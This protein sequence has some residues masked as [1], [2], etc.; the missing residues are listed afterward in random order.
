M[1]FA[2]LVLAAAL[3]PASLVNTFVGTS[4]TQIG[5]P[6]DDFPGADAPFGM[7]QWSP[8]T[9]SQ[10]AG[11][12]YEYGDTAIT[13]FSLTHL[14]GPG[15]SVFG[16]FAML[17]TTGDITSPATAKQ[18]FSHATE[19][20]APGDYA[21]TLGNPGIRAELVARAH[22][23]IGRFT[24]PATTRANVLVNVASN[25][26]GVTDA[27]A[28]IVGNDEIEG[29]AASGYFCGMPDRYSVYFVARFNRPFVASGVWGGG[30]GAGS[31]AWVRFDTTRNPNVEVNVAISFTDAA[32]ARANLDREGR[33][34]DLVAARNTVLASWNAM[35]SRIA[36]E[37][38]TS[39]QQRQ[40]Y[41]ALYHTMLHPNLISDVDGR[42]RGFD[43]AIHHARVGREYANFSDWDIY[44][45]EIPLIALLA[46]ARASD[47]MQSLV[48]AYAQSGW[49]PRW[50]LVNAP[51]SVMGGDS[52]DPV[53]AGGYAF[54]ARDFDTKT[55]L[56]GMVKGSSD[57][58]SPPWDGWYFERPESREYQRQGYISNTHTTSVSPVPNGASETLEYALDDFSIA[59]FARD[60]GNLGVYRTYL[61]RSTN[62]SN[63]FN[64]ATGLIAPRDGT[65]AFTSSPLNENGQDGFQE[66]NAAQYTWMVP[67][68]L[69]DLARGMG[70]A[71]NTAAALD[72]FFTQLNAGQDKPY[73]WLGNEPSIG[74]PWVYLSVGEPWRTQ[75][76]VRDAMTT[77][78]TL[79]PDGIPGN[80]DLGTMSAWYVWSAIG[81]YPQNPSV[82]ILDI[83][84]PLFPHI[85]LQS[86]H[87]PTLVIHAPAAAANAPYVDALRVNGR[88]TQRAWFALPMTGM[89]HLH[90]DLS[91]QPNHAWGAKPNDAPPSFA[92]RGGVH[93]PPATASTLSLE[94]IPPLAPGA[95]AILGGTLTN[96]DSIAQSYIVSASVSQ[97]ATIA[98]NRPVE[99]LTLPPGKG[100]VV[101]FQLAIPRGAPVG[102][103]DA[104]IHVRTTS[105]ALLPPAHV[106][107]R[108]ANNAEMPRLA[109]IENRFNDTVMPFDLRTNAIGATV[110]V[111]SGPRDAVLSLDNRRLFVA[112]RDSQSV[113]VVD[114]IASKVIATLKVGSSPNGIAL[115]PDGTVWVANFDD[116]TVQSI[117][118]VTFATGKPI[119]V[120]AGP[121]YITVGPDNAHLYV[122]DQ[123]SNDLTVVDLK[124][125]STAT[126]PTGARPTGITLSA[127]GAIAYVANNGDRTVSVIDLRAARIVATIPAGAEAQAVAISP[128]GSTAFTSNFMSNTVTEMDLHTDKAIRSIV[129]GGQ[130]FDVRFTPQG[131][132]VTILHQDNALVRFD[133]SGKITTTIFL[134]SGGAYSI[135]LP[136]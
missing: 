25:Q 135:A 116:G 20:S 35:L 51:T 65:G 132:L 19:A 28:R 1:M 127:D 92:P 2:A 85:V 99:G 130:P 33:S 3:N 80:D 125:F 43:G 126:L 77:L 113:S 112:D 63:L 30:R 81:L 76:V 14:S 6:I 57:T 82:R 109:W 91:T 96:H 5:G 55:A 41:T 26:A 23:G 104:S 134:G 50:A 124:S 9:P 93:F 29:F 46:P 15:C 52:V 131:D 39:T 72:R 13:G 88:A 105:G 10:N 22:S 110:T 128:D 49:L 61:A 12:G 114:T 32:G 89:T 11:G 53:L 68:D 64:T 70:G 37:G 42:Y 27:S 67:Q 18:T 121:R 56:A 4:G 17:P 118:P 45:T 101:A 97:P 58:T 107:M 108:V 34:W 44:R 136:H 83:G 47:M 84:S 90:F 8:D 123:T 79:A 31:G 120:G 115:A 36:I 111:G 117:D 59:E 16:D 129:V 119:R 40:F 38:G 102:L 94:T 98:P 103:Y 75:G 86:P 24:F 73:A 100:T 60:T 78:W 71:K 106:T 66:G 95:G 74:S 54:G 122:T 48:D 7:V 69:A 133:A 21:V 87:G 62:W